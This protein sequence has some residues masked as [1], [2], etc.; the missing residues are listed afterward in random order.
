MS[1][2]TRRI[3]L[4]VVV[5]FVLA[6]IVYVGWVWIR[7]PINSEATITKAI[8]GLFQDIPEN[9]VYIHVGTEPGYAP[10]TVFKKLRRSIVLR[11]GKDNPPVIPG[12]VSNTLLIKETRKGAANADLWNDFFVASGGMKD[13]GMVVFE[14]K[15][16]TSESLDEQTLSKWITDSKESIGK[17]VSD[18]EWNDNPPLV[19]YRAF[20][21]DYTLKVDVVVDA[22]SRLD[23]KKTEFKGKLS[24]S[25]G[26]QRSY[27]F[28]SPNQVVFAFCAKKLTRDSKMGPSGPIQIGSTAATDNSSPWEEAKLVNSK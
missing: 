17:L 23:I 18:K 1:E 22:M 19:V 20:R 5:L 16:I 25:S 26:D 6:I 12:T 4:T 13:S 10:G 3:V 27:E 15:K 14:C 28:N 11:P 7:Q 24:G 8:H 21:G 2:Q 9:E